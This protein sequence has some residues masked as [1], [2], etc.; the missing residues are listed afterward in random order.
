MY[1]EI[2]IMQNNWIYQTCSALTFNSRHNST[3]LNC[4]W[5]FKTIGKDPSQKVFTQAHVIKVVNNL[6]PFRLDISIDAVV[7]TS[8]WIRSIVSSWAIMKEDNKKIK[9]KT[10]KYAKIY[11][12][13]INFLV[14]KF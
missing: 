10:G 11:L 4:R 2:L 1:L 8:G 5:L 12:R 6:S 3:L 7:H 13:E 14:D 9:N